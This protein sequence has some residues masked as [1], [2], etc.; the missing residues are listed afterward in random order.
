MAQAAWHDGETTSRAFNSVDAHPL[1]NLSPY[2]N[3]L[4]ITISE[5]FETYL[6]TLKDKQ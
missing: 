1:I 4:I 3:L 6:R 2:G 5:M